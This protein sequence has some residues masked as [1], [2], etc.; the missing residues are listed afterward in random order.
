MKIHIISDIH[1]EG[2][3]TPN[4]IWKFINPTA[5][6]AVIAG[7]IEARNSAGRNFELTMTEI[8]SRFE[9]VICLAGN[10]EFYGKDITWRPDTKKMPSNVHFLDRSCF[11]LDDVLFV[12]ATLWSDFKNEDFFIVNAAARMI[13]DFS[14][15]TKHNGGVRFLPKDAAKLHYQDKEY[16][17]QVL[18]N[19]LNAYKKIVVVT[20]FMPG[21][22][23]AHSKWK[24]MGSDMLNYYFSANCDDLIA[25]G[26]PT[27]WIFGHTHD[28]RIMSINGIQ[29]VC[30]PLGYGGENK[31]FQQ[32]EIDV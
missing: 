5:P 11:E 6:V 13:N 17:R 3:A 31:D 24:T 9:H 25:T 16:I 26:K 32:M 19:P 27:H 28:M 7:D 20:H 23:F 22:Q 29:F 1:A 18:E 21:Y 15:I 12:G 2:F 8:A 10:H 14:L 30:N 4:R